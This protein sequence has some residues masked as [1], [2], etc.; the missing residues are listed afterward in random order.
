MN[1]ITCA[2]CKET[3]NINDYNA[4][5]AARTSYS[6]CRL[7]MQSYK[8]ADKENKKPRELDLDETNVLC[9]TWQGGKYHGHILDKNNTFYPRV[10]G[11]QKSFRYDDE[12]KDSIYKLANKW[13]KEKSN[14]LN[15]SSNRYKII[16]DDKNKPLYV[17]VQLSKDY[18]TLTDFNQLDFI[19]SHNLCVSCSSKE[20]AKQYVAC[21]I[22]NKLVSFHGHITGLKMVDHINGYPL[23][24]R[25]KNLIETT[26]SENNK[27]RSNIHKTY[28]TVID[29]KFKGT[30]IYNDHTQQFK[31]VTLSEIFNDLDS[32]K[33]WI[34]AKVDSLNSKT[35]NEIDNKKQLK[36]EFEK[37]MEKHA[38]NFKWRDVMINEFDSSIHIQENEENNSES[39]S[40]IEK[41]HVAV[42]MSIIKETT[43]NLFKTIDPSWSIP[44]EF[45]ASIKLEHIKHQ[46]N[47]YKFCTKCDKWTLINN[48]HKSS[49]KH[50]GLD[51]R[52]K[53]CAKL[54]S[55]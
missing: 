33:K 19:K 13:R 41:K 20:N 24:N 55:K 5:E 22:D 15:L 27:N 32:C 39:N 40:I 52:C 17:I 23:D 51:T 10:D 11:K 25:R 31:K 50:D 34:L 30:V 38:E 18:I 53:D 45:N 36:D 26:A 6:R 42:K 2:K 35:L 44:Q 3:K 49:S 8:N 28:F 7:C 46:D 14:E 47:E 12:N 43:Y 54:R 4:S 1:T 29:N 48:F 9:K 37:I 16:F 21:T